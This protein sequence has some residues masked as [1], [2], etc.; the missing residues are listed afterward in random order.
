M[1]WVFIA[2]VPASKPMSQSPAMH[3]FAYP[4]LRKI[5]KKDLARAHGNKA[6]CKRNKISLDKIPV[7]KKFLIVFGFA[8]FPLLSISQNAL[9]IE[10]LINFK[11][12]SSPAVSPDGKNMCFSIEEI[13]IEK[14]KGF[15]DLYV[16]SVDGKNN[17][18]ITETPEKEWSP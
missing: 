11:R 6:F 18:R 1:I 14:N 13:N 7:M 12:V 15:K 3:H 8:A 10:S 5:G 2:S 4:N 16:S 17:K 9:T